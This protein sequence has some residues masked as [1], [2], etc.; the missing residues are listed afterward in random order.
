MIAAPQNSLP[1]SKTAKRPKIW[2]KIKF[3]DSARD[4]L[5]SD[6]ARNETTGSVAKGEMYL[7]AEKRQPM[8][9]FHIVGGVA[10]ALMDR[11]S[12]AVARTR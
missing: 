5:V 6:S 11:A 1:S 8:T 9:R 4:K 2:Q 12:F 7:A 10:R 3:H